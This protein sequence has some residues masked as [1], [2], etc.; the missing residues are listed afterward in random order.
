[1]S[2]PSRARERRLLQSIVACLALVPILAGSAGVLRGLC[3]FDPIHT[4]SLAGDSHVYYLSG[5]L[6]AIGLGFLSTVPRIETQGER[7]RLLTALVLIGGFARLYGIARN[8]LPGPVMEAALI[9]E[10]VVT[11]GL[12]LW[13]ERLNAGSPAWRSFRAQRP[14]KGIGCSIAAWTGAT[15]A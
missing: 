9:M 13:R 6:L 14:E 2:S 15:K 8:G 11:P 4:P 12:A 7:F 5:L 3:A 10:I 1:M